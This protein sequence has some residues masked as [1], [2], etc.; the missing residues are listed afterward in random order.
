MATGA[1]I[2]QYITYYKT[3]QASLKKRASDLE[4]SI[5][6]FKIH[7]EAFAEFIK[8]DAP[9]SLKETLL[10]FSEQISSKESAEAFVSGLLAWV[11]AQN[12]EDRR[13]LADLDALREKW[14][15]QAQM[16]DKAI[17]TGLMATLLRWPPP[18]TTANEAFACL[19]ADPQREVA[20]VVRA[21]KP[22]RTDDRKYAGSTAIPVPV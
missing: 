3:Q 7:Q 1:L 8:Q 15:G 10:Y 17:T 6:L 11:R 20:G 16:F 2:A 12:P 14:P 18:G 4:K 19:V 13:P 22:H 5:T 21:S 9:I